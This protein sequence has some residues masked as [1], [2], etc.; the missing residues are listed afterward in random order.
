MFM[1]LLFFK[2]LIPPYIHLKNAPLLCLLVFLVTNN[3][4]S[5]IWTYPHQSDA[6]HDVYEFFMHVF[7]AVI[8]VRL[9]VLNA[10]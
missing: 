9:T 4:C 6:D 5:F 8:Y 1:I 3:S 10:L 2:C 7:A